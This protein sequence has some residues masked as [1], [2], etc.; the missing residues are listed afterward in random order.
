M[1]FTIVAVGATSW[2]TKLV[3]TNYYAS[4]SDVFIVTVWLC[5]SISLGLK[6][7]MPH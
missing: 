5:F 7:R 2:E 1:Y 3:C 4:S 6:Y